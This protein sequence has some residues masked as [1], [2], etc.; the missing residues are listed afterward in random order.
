MERSTADTKERSPVLSPCRVVT[1]VT[2]D[3][4]LEV[5]TNSEL[6]INTH[7]CYYAADPNTFGQFYRQ[8]TKC[9]PLLV[10]LL[11]YTL[12][13]TAGNALIEMLGL[14]LLWN[15]LQMS[16]LPCNCFPISS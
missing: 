13:T 9:V 8:S 11:C 5:L 7:N 3:S 4:S 15:N 14:L 2:H 6:T 1:S 12:T 16:Y 10:A